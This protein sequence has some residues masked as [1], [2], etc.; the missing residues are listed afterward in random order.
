MQGWCATCH[1]LCHQ[2]QVYRSSSRGCRRDRQPYPTPKLSYAYNV[3]HAARTAPSTGRK[4]HVVRRPPRHLGD[5]VRCKH[6][7]L[8]H[9]GGQHR[10]REGL[11]AEAL[12]ENLGRGRGTAGGGF[13]RRGVRAPKILEGMEGTMFVREGGGLAQVQQRLALVVHRCYGCVAAAV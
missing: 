2:A 3:W 5:C 13:L 8:C 7:G 4:E 6:E 12:E 1:S 9:D 10:R 11:A